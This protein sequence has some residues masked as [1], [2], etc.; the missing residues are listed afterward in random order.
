MAKIDV[1][2]TF[3]SKEDLLNFLKKQIASL[4][5][6]KKKTKQQREELSF[7]K[8]L[9]TLSTAD[10]ISYPLAWNP[11]D[12]PDFRLFQGQ[13]DIGIEHT[14][15]TNQNVESI[16][17]LAKEE[18]KIVMIAADEFGPDTPA[19]TTEQKREIINRPHKITTPGFGDD[20]MEKAWS[21]WILKTIENKTADFRKPDFNKYNDN[22]LL[23]DDETLVALAETKTALNYFLLAFWP[24]WSQNNRYSRIFIQRHDGLVDISPKGWRVYSRVNF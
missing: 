17:A 6:Y 11:Q 14:I 18:G 19:I 22:W 20:G 2:F 5:S 23:I 21:R 13:K 15:A 8:F 9:A 16:F 7:Y 3:T 12:R 24:Y 10:S 4:A 1:S